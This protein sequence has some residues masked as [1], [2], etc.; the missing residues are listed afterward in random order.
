MEAVGCNS[1]H[2]LGELWNVKEDL[3]ERTGEPQAS[4]AGGVAQARHSAS[5]YRRCL[6]WER[7]SLFCHIGYFDE[8]RHVGHPLV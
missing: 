2:A 7:T 4:T 3:G 6:E 8:K 1:R 5:R